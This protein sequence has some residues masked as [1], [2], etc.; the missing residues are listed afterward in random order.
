[1]DE[2]SALPPAAEGALLAH[3]RLI[4]A[5]FAVLVADH[6]DGHGVIDDVE[7]RIGAPDG[8]EDPGAVPDRAFAVER[9]A[10]AEIARTLRAVRERLDHGRSGRAAV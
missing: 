5:V 1:M 4:E 8:Q 2:P 6:A 3:R 9:A 10:E 7:R